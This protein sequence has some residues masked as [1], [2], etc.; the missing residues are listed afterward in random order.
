MTL[1]KSIQPWP[2]LSNLFCILK[3]WS[4]QGK[5]AISCHICCFLLL[6]CTSLQSNYAYFVNFFVY[7]LSLPLCL[8]LCL[9]ISSGHFV[10]GC[11]QDQAHGRCV[12]FNVSTQGYILTYSVSSTNT[13]T[14]DETGWN[15]NITVTKITTVTIIIMVMLKGSEY[16]QKVLIHIHL[17]LLLL[18][19]LLSSY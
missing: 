11:V 3:Y 2:V 9:C 4:M 16:V 12:Q 7:P 14:R 19:I 5:S 10:V 13:Q 18:L 17:W 6:V 8:C 1:A 15:S